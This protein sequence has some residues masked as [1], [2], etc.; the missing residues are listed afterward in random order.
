MK[1]G[2]GPELYPGTIEAEKERA[3]AGYPV[4]FSTGAEYA[5]ISDRKSVV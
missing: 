5:W 3:R 4:Y 1:K 2:K